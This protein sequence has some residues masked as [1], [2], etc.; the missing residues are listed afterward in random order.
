MSVDIEGEEI[1]VLKTL[2][3]NKYNIKYICVEIFNH[4]KKSK[5]NNLKVIKYLKKNGYFLK[6]KTAINYIFKKKN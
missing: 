2:N 5:E 3:L 1:K 4:N 6:D